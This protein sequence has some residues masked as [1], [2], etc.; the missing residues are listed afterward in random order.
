[1]KHFPGF[2]GSMTTLEAVGLYLMHFACLW[3]MLWC[4][5][6]AECFMISFVGGV[7]LVTGGPLERYLKKHCSKIPW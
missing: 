3:A 4:N 7:L 6:A 1:M 2:G 5:V